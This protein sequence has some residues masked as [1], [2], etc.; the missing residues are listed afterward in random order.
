MTRRISTEC[1]AAGAFSVI[2]GG[3]LAAG[4]WPAVVVIQFIFIITLH[5]HYE[6]KRS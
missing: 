4:D 5:A 1:L 3:A 6:A 2:A